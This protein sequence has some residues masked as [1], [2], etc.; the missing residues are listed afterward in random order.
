M[1]E[2]QPLDDIYILYLPLY[3]CLKCRT[4]AI[5]THI[6]HQTR[7]YLKRPDVYQLELRTV[8]QRLVTV[9]APCALSLLISSLLLVSDTPA[10]PWHFGL[11]SHPPPPPSLS[12][13]LSFSRLPYNHTLSRLCSRPTFTFAGILDATLGHICQV[14]LKE[15]YSDPP[16]LLI[17]PS[18]TPINILYLFV[19]HA[20]QKCDVRLTVT[21]Q[22]QILRS[23]PLRSLTRPS[24]TSKHPEFV[25]TRFSFLWRPALAASR[26]L[27]MSLFK[28]LFICLFLYGNLMI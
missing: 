26:S 25:F 19:V 1:C 24:F 12:P 14:S 7:A 15:F 2:L 6:N 8:W 22:Q 18:F 9:T 21:C 10:C 28:H 20:Q 17:R 16:G 27:F 23:H 3:L 13:C 4:Y 11:R 5:H